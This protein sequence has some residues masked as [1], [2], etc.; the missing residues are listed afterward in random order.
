MEPAK[1][2]QA[3]WDL[4]W[5]LSALVYNLLITEFLASKGLEWTDVSISMAAISLAFISRETYWQTRTRSLFRGK[6]QLLLPWI[7]SVLPMVGVALLWTAPWK[8][9]RTVRIVIDGSGNMESYFR[10]VLTELKIGED[11]VREDIDI[12]L[13]IFGA[14]LSG[15]EGCDDYA[16][17]VPTSPKYKSLDAISSTVDEILPS[18]TNGRGGLHEALLETIRRS[19]TGSRWTQILVVTRGADEMCDSLN[20]QQLL[21]AMESSGGSIELVVMTVGEMGDFEIGEVEKYALGNHIHVDDISD[22]SREILAYLNSSPSSPSHR[23]LRVRR[24]LKQAEASL[25]SHPRRSLLL[26]L[27]ALDVAGDDQTWGPIS[28][29]YLRS[30]LSSSGRNHLIG[31]GEHKYFA[32]IEISLQGQWLVSISYK[33]DA[34]NSIVRND[35][36]LKD[37]GDWKAVLWD[38]TNDFAFEGGFVLPEYEE[39]FGRPVFSPDERWLVMGNFE[40]NILL[41]RIEGGGR[42]T[43][44]DTDN[45]GYGSSV[46]ATAFSP[47]SRWLVAAFESQG[48]CAWKLGAGGSTGIPQE[49]GTSE[50]STYF[51]RFTS[52]GRWLIGTGFSPNV[53]R[54]QVQSGD[55]FSAGL[56][57]LDLGDDL[58]LSLITDDNRWLITMSDTRRL[59][60]WDIDSPELRNPHFSAE[61]H[62]GSPTGLSASSDGGWLATFDDFTS[63]IWMLGDDP[64]EIL[65][66]P[67][68][69]GRA[70]PKSI[71]FSHNSKLAA[72]LNSEGDICVW[73]LSAD[74]LRASPLRL[75]AHNGGAG[76]EVE[77]SPADEW[78]VSIGGDSALRLWRVNRIVDLYEYRIRNPRM[79]P[80]HVFRGHDVGISDFFFGIGN[81]W[82]VTVGYDDTVIMWDLSSS[83]PF[84][85]PETYS[86]PCGYGGKM[87]LSLDDRWLALG[88]TWKD[89]G[90]LIEITNSAVHTWDTCL[91]NGEEPFSDLAFGM[92]GDLLVTGST[93]GR[94]VLWELAQPERPLRSRTLFDLGEP[95]TTLDL[96]P[97]DNWLVVG[98]LYGSIVVWNMQGEPSAANPI[99]LASQGSEITGVEYCDKGGWFA[100]ASRGGTVAIWIFP[101][102]NNVGF[103]PI[104]EAEK[105][106]LQL[107]SL[108]LDCKWLAVSIASD[109]YLWK[110]NDTGTGY[111]GLTILS[112]HTANITDLDFSYGGRFVGASAFDRTVY[113]W[114][115]V[116][117]SPAVHP[118]RLPKLAGDVYSIA[119]SHDEEW[120][121]TG[122]LVDATGD[123]EIGL[124]SIHSLMEL[125]TPQ[126]I[127][128]GATDGSPTGMSFSSNDEWLAV[129]AG[130]EIHRFSLGIEHTNSLA[131]QAANRNLSKEEWLRYSPLDQYPWLCLKLPL[132][133]GIEQ[134]EVDRP[135][136]QSDSS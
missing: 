109:V 40:G 56:Q 130:S 51:L 95:V 128:L 117:D 45:C 3:R 133:D 90:S 20:A 126:P 70:P 69:C 31:P 111:E 67:I 14:G 13:S 54:W 53:F 9:T 121:A 19:G 21:D 100:Y 10:E 2:R 55:L 84:A 94:V 8:E 35:E 43:L 59:D 64:T 114:E 63:T 41:W 61:P 78:L 33:G 37:T 82:L 106:P 120:I 60:I 16:T 36:Q 1:T 34:L 32:G 73:K 129:M 102:N 30:I 104:M 122:S 131:C 135:A 66:F 136:I 57:S 127:M 44:I 58:A 123:H 115:L 83:T 92:D 125:S 46:T 85:I 119:F 132:G 39:G 47:D 91:G 27:Q 87:E 29:S 49:I 74:S 107:L 76:L 25:D 28:E 11:L 96:S 108:A 38:L 80:E 17:L 124:W 93:S 79:A 134:N 112:D 101:P 5:A 118:I 110:L 12:E 6:S 7:L 42:P 48:F 89:G 26:T 103:V 86:I 50:G 98:G 52:D 62:E 88:S 22:L 81:R 72:L 97:D 116:E 18:V 75:K 23:T 77:F 24:L 15:R 71:A 99:Q 113:L 4:V 65:S 68:D 105:G